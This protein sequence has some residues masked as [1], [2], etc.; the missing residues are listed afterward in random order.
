MS[1]TESS[2]TSIFVAQRS[3][4][5]TIVK[6]TTSYLFI[7]K[8]IEKETITGNIKII[9]WVKYQLLTVGTGLKYLPKRFR[10]ITAQ[11]FKI[12]KQFSEWGIFLFSLEIY[13]L[14]SPS[15]HQFPPDCCNT[16]ALSPLRLINTSSSSR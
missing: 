3:E 2:S 4:E 10:Q 5:D 15:Q 7:V 11:F 16:L 13:E 14:F 9:I 8:I 6:P 1:D 12:F